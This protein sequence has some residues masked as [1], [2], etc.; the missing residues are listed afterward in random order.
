[1]VIDHALAE[2]FDHVARSLIWSKLAQFDLSHSSLGRFFRKLLIGHFTH[3]CFGMAGC[4]PRWAVL[5]RFGRG[6]VLL[7]ESHTS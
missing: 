2:I 7:C 6:W 1:M 5:W 4:L 3:A